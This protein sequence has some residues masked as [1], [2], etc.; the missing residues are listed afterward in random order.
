M[1]GRASNTRPDRFNASLCSVLVF[2]AGCLLR[3]ALT[4]GFT[5]PLVTPLGRTE[6]RGA[7][8]C[9][10]KETPLSRSPSPFLQSRR[11]MGKRSLLLPG[12][13]RS[14]GSP[15]RATPRTDE[16]TTEK[17]RGR[18]TKRDRERERERAPVCALEMRV[19]ETFFTRSLSLSFSLSEDMFRTEAY[20]GCEVQITGRSSDSTAPQEKSW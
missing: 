18:R 6:Q 16:H 12:T 9:R 8:L 14:H 3:L 7:L 15:S 20:L 19:R 1:E 4:V 10:Q 11:W 2:W 5:A 17:E 13:A